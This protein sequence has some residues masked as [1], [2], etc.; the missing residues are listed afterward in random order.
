MNVIEPEGVSLEVKSKVRPYYNE[1][2]GYLSRA[3]EDNDRFYENDSEWQ[4]I[5]TTIDLLNTATEKNYDRFKLTLHRGANGFNF[6][7]LTSYKQKLAG[8]I[9]FLHGNT[10]MMNHH[11]LVVCQAL[12]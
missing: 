4:Q 12:L 3:P 5:N 6:V 1:L 11:L 9:N 10:F 7:R 8:L 2:Q